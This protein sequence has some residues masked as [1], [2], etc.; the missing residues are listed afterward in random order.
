MDFQVSLTYQ[1]C[2][3]HQFVSDLIT[4]PSQNSILHSS[5]NLDSIYKDFHLVCGIIDKNFFSTNEAPSY[6]V[7]TFHPNHFPSDNGFVIRYFQIHWRLLCIIHRAV[8]RQSMNNCFAMKYKTAAPMPFV[9]NY[10]YY[11]KLMTDMFGYKHVN[12]LTSTAKS[13]PTSFLSCEVWYR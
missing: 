8:Y 13:R 10:D 2:W 11:L 3:S 5:S 12:K 9:V 7:L 1:V 6:Y 4:Q